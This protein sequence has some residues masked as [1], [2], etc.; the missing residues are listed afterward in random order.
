MNHM[1]LSAYNGNYR[2]LETAS[3]QPLF[4]VNDSAIRTDQF[5]L[6]GS[7]D[8]LL[9]SPGRPPYPF[10]LTTLLGTSKVPILIR[11]ISR[12]LHIRN[13]SKYERNN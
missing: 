8:L 7:R 11:T 13:Y 9:G 4:R 3:S 12:T 1:T 10:C 5:A 6:R 2:T